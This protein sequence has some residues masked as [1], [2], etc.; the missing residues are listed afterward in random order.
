MSAYKIQHDY[1]FDAEELVE[2]GEPC[3]DVIEPGDRPFMMTLSTFLNDDGKERLECLR[4]E[5]S[6]ILIDDIDIID[7]GVLNDYKRLLICALL[8]KLR[9]KGIRV[10]KG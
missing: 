10:F 8:I 1:L 2:E 4:E 9:G 5:D 7:N 6:L 3:F